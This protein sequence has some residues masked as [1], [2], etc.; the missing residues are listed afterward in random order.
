MLAESAGRSYLAAIMMPEYTPKK[1]TPPG[2]ATVIE[3]DALEVARGLPAASIDLIATDPPYFRVKDEPWDRQWD[4]RRAF[5]AWI[6]Q[7]C[8]EWQRILKPNGSLYVF[9][10][11]RMA[12]EVANV[13]AERFVLLNEI[14]WVKKAGRH[15]GARKEDLRSYFPQTERIVF[16]EQPGA[17]S[18]Y[19]AADRQLR[20]EI[21][22]PLRAYLDGERA[23][24]GASMA[25]CT[26]AI[27][28]QMAGHYFNRSQWTFLPRG[29]Y[30]AL[31]D[32]F[33]E[34]IGGAVACLARS[35]DELEEEY[36]ELRAEYD[37]RRR[38]LSGLRR[39]FGVTA[40][41][42]YTDVWIF[43]TVQHYPGKHPCEKPLALMEHIVKASSRPGD[44][45]AD[46]FAG[47]G[48]TGEA[49]VRNGRDALLVELSPA[50]ARAAR[51]RCGVKGVTTTKS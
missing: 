4:N 19:A 3:G 43:D 45:V 13:I 5:L 12:R 23:R 28:T 17:D 11:P 36:Q 1:P 2:R 16:A 48:T 8:E 46:F 24:A 27:G 21:F 41:V 20:A 44:T 37:R 6:G 25:E 40:E 34:R 10:G 47:S 9:A 22:E 26:R 29:A 38:I 49:A 42:P 35:Y 30:E 31:Q 14:F 15:L 50:W 33:A 7:L 39:A 32:L 18:Q 51:E